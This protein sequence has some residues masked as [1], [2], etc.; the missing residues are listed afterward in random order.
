MFG[1]IDPERDREYEEYEPNGHDDL[2]LP[3]RVSP[4]GGNDPGFDRP[5]EMPPGRELSRVTE[6]PWWNEPT[7]GDN[8]ERREEYLPFASTGYDDTHLSREDGW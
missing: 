6:L 4:A 5:F 8:W 7:M 3:Y 1:I 2:D